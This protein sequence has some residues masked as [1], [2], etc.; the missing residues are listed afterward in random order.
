MNQ[1]K[2]IEKTGENE[3]TITWQDGSLHHL[4]FKKLRD[5]CPCAT[6]SGETVLLK[7]S[8]PSKVFLDTPGRYTLSGIDPVGNYAVTFRWGDGHQ[9]GIYS[10]D[11]LYLM[12]KT[13][14]GH[15]H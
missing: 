6:C 1:P 7:T 5:L 2:K 15:H 3:L 14:T 8:K 13:P 12:G 10:W 9:T 11:F 4:P